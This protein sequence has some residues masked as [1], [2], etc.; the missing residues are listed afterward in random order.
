MKKAFTI[1][2]FCVAGASFGQTQTRILA[3]DIIKQINEGR[4]VEYTGVEIE[5]DLD[6]T[7]LSNQRLERHSSGWFDTNE[8]YESVV[9]VPVRFSNCTFLGDVLA[10]YHL[11]RRNETYIAHFEKDAIFKNCTFKRSSEFKYS[12]FNGQATFTGCTFYDVANFKYAEFSYGPMFNSVKFERG[13]D[14]KYTD[15][16]R[17]TTFEKATFYGYANFKYTKFRSPLNMQGTA[18]RGDEDFKY[19]RIDGRSFTSHL[20]ERQ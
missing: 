11:D 10:Y 13:A 14:F 16:P 6:L 9:E 15:F 18:F 2:L 1:L 7:N 8:T 4:T 20:L 5:G 17:E 3:R 12:E 19:T